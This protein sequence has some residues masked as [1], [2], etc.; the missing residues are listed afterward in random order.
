MNSYSFLCEELG[1][2]D[3]SMQRD[4]KYANQQHSGS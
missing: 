1:P 4:A 2:F 3:L